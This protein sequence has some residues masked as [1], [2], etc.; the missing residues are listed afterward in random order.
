[1]PG[2]LC[3]RAAPLRVVCRAAADARAHAFDELCPRAPACDKL[4]CESSFW[5]RVWTCAYWRSFESE[6]S[7]L[8]AGEEESSGRRAPRGGRA[9]PHRDQRGAPSA[10]TTLLRVKET[11]QHVVIYTN[12]RAKAVIAWTERH[13]KCFTHLCFVATAIRRPRSARINA[14]SSAS[15]TQ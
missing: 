13:N 5:C 4:R 7:W 10:P 1:M 6:R 14:S 9:L 3:G 11:K 2:C 15:V 8:T 12:E